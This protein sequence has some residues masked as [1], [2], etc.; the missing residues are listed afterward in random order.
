MP[1]LDALA[2]EMR[3]SCELGAAC[4]RQHCGAWHELD[5]VFCQPNGK[6]LHG[7]NLTRRDLRASVLM[8]EEVNPTGL[9][10]DPAPVAQLAGGTA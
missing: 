5:L 2:E 3:G 4:R 10:P 6:P 1:H 7:H 9:L 8:R